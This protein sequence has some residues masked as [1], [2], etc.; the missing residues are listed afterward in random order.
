MGCM[1]DLAP[2][3]ANLD[4]VNRQKHV[5]HQRAQFRLRRIPPKLKRNE[6]WRWLLVGRWACQQGCYRNQVFLKKNLVSWV[7]S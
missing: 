4:E 6:C 1:K 3:A 2:L 7:M 5:N